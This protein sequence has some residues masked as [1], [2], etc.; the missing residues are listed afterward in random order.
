MGL[1]EIVFLLV[2]D[3]A[4]ERISGASGFFFFLLTQDKL[5]L[6]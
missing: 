6:H 1:W 2:N 5:L 3:G 4:C